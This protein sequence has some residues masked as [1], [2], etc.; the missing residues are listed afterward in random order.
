MGIMLSINQLEYFVNIASVTATDA[1]M[2]SAAFLISTALMV[3]KTA[4]VRKNIVATST[5]IR[6]T[7]I[8]R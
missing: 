6:G 5:I 3:A 7:C 2:K 8:I 1:D 4:S